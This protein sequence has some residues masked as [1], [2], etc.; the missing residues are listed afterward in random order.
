MSVALWHARGDIISAPGYSSSSSAPTPQPWIFSTPGQGERSFI[1]TGEPLIGFMASA[2]AAYRDF[3]H[4]NWIVV[5]STSRGLL[6][7]PTQL[8]NYFAPSWES[9]WRLS[10]HID[11]VRVESADHRG[12]S[13]SGTTLILRP[14]GSRPGGG[15]PQ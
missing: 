8:R 7:P 3:Q 10:C 12:R 6:E 11:A 14:S 5:A 9:S 13:A 1:S 2:S 15:L 4:L